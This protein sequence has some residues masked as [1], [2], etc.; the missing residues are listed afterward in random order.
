M[1]ALRVF[2][3]LHAAVFSRLPQAP[4]S[5]DPEAA[6]VWDVR[7]VLAEEKRRVSWGGWEGRRLCVWGGWV[8][9]SEVEQLGWGGGV[10][11]KCV[12]GQCSAGCHR[13]P[14]QW[15]QL[16]QCGMCATCWLRKSGG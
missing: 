2:E 1:T 6:A 16:Q 8:G 15:T 14:C 3:A 13:P 4:L 12:G 11:S 9:L 7:N 10:S 5:L